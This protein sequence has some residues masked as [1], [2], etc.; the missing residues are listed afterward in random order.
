M[1]DGARR[2]V[3]D[4]TDA[5]QRGDLTSRDREACASR[6]QSFLQFAVDRSKWR[7]LESVGSQ[8]GSTSRLDA[9]LRKHAGAIWA[10]F[11]SQVL[12]TKLAP[13]EFRIVAKMWLGLAVYSDGSD[14]TRS[15]LESSG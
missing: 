4:A 12:G 1:D 9:I 10:V 3:S 5:L 2:L 7:Q 15:L 8:Q 6:P 14:G 11:P 13:M